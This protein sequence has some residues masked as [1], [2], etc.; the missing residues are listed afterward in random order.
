MTSNPYDQFAYR[1]AP[2]EW[3]A[4]ERLAVASLLHGGPRPRRDRYRVLELGCGNAANLIPLAYYRPHSEFVGVDGAGTQTALAQSRC[5]ELRLQNVRIHHADF[6]AA[7][8]L[9]EGRF[10]YILAHGVLSWVGEATRQALLAIC[11]RRLAP[12]GLVYLNYNCRPG[13]SIRG[14][15]RDLLMAQTAHGGSLQ[16]RAL[17]AQEVSARMAQAYEQ[18]ES[19]YCRLLSNEFRMVC[20]HDAAYIA[21]EYLAEHNVAFWRSE[22]MA[23]AA[24]HGLVY[25]ADADFSYESGRIPPGLPEQLAASGIHGRCPEDTLDLLVHRQLHSP[26]L[27]Q[28]PLVRRLPEPAELC[29]LAAASPLVRRRGGKGRPVFVHPSTA[30]VEAKEP[31]MCK[32]LDRLQKVWPRGERL[33][34]LVAGSPALLQD[35]LLLHRNGLIDLRR[36]PSE[37]VGVDPQRLNAFETRFDDFQTSP[38]HF[39]EHAHRAPVPA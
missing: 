39:R 26:I 36:A 31:S 14:M 21:H 5:A 1:C 15:V 18:H 4:P 8:A 7:D 30:E 11:A 10:D 38:Y 12:G 23:L 37:E 6:L 13:W 20:N 35:L 19:P 33:G 22:F 34:D 16:Q 17:A 24:Q 32:V 27:A 3:S 2:I 25:V 9:L 28:A 29:D